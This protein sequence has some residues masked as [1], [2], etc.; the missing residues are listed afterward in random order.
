MQVVMSQRD[1]EIARE[2]FIVHAIMFMTIMRWIL[3]CHSQSIDS[4]NRIIWQY[5]TILTDAK[6]FMAVIRKSY[7]FTTI[8]GCDH[9]SDPVIKLYHDSHV[10]S[11][12]I[13]RCQDAIPI[14]AMQTWRIVK[15][16]I[17]RQIS[18]QHVSALEL[19]FKF[20]TIHV[21]ANA[22]AILLWAHD[23]HKNYSIL[24]QAYSPS[25]GLRSGKYSKDA[26]LTL[27]AG[28][29]FR[30]GNMYYVH[31]RSLSRKDLNVC[32]PKLKSPVFP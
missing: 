26:R 28:L 8:H 2:I 6:P 13:A 31:C 9:K 23:T 1:G 17:A 15:W 30:I 4:S 27:W 16:R 32:G 25:F 18:S 5:H 22:A 3:L 29:E 11:F 20:L 21:I 24:G 19:A 14:Q 10:Y 12:W 7:G